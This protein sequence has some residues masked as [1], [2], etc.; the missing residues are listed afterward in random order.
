MNEEL[1]KFGRKC[2]W[3]NP[4][5]LPRLLPG[6][7]SGKQSSVLK[8]YATSYFLKIHTNICLFKPV[9]HKLSTDLV[10]ITNIFLKNQACNNV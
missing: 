6:G 3:S 2:S 8:F 1:K 10:L 5:N 7:I 4:Y 9:F